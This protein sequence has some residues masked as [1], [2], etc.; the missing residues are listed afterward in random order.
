MYYQRVNRTSTPIYTIAT[1]QTI[2]LLPGVNPD[3]HPAHALLVE[4]Q[5]LLQALLQSSIDLLRAVGLEEAL[6][7]P[8]LVAGDGLDP[9]VA[10]VVQ[11]GR[12]ANTEDRLWR[13]GSDEKKKKR[14][15][16]LSP[17]LGLCSRRLLAPASK[18]FYS[19]CA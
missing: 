3:L 15:E 2:D 7:H 14:C 17:R 9:G 13:R 16:R 10:H 5:C 18:C 6:A 12:G 1:I 19:P 4:V 11:M 8:A